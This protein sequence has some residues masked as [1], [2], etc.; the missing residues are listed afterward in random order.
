[1]GHISY[2]KQCRVLLDGCRES[3]PSSSR[4]RPLTRKS[5]TVALWM[6]VISLPGPGLLWGLLTLGTREDSSSCRSTF[7]LTTRS[8]LPTCSSRLRSSTRTSTSGG[9]CLEMLKN[10]WSPARTIAQVMDAIH[11]LMSEPNCENPLNPE[12]AS[13]YVEDKDK[14]NEEAAAQTTK[15]ATAE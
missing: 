10:S 8:S 11:G 7:R 15:Y 13:L 3:F 9:V 12:A 14:F 1:M 5:G 4:T 2:S 6:T